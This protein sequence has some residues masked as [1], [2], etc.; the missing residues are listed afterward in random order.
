MSKLAHSDWKSMMEI[1]AREAVANG[2]QDLALEEL[3][4]ELADAEAHLRYVEADDFAA[5]NGALQ[6]AWD[7]VNHVRRCIGIVKGKH[8]RVSTT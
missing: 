8:D 5:T 6:T 1:E 7:W 3:N 2:T 4:R